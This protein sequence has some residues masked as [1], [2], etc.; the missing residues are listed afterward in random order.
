MSGLDTSA[1]KVSE[2]EDRYFVDSNVLINFL[3]N[4]Y[5]HDIPYFDGW[6]VVFRYLIAQGVIAIPSGIMAELKKKKGQKKKVYE[7][8]QLREIKELKPSNKVHEEKIAEYARKGTSQRILQ[9]ANFDAVAS[10]VK[11]SK[12]GTSEMLNDHLGID[13]GDLSLLATAFDPHFQCRGVRYLV[14]SEFSIA[15]QMVINDISPDKRLVATLEY[16]QQN[17]S[18]AA[19][20]SSLNKQPPDNIF[21]VKIPDAIQDIGR[22]LSKQHASVKFLRMPEFAKAVA[23]FLP[24]S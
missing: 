1:A 4:F 22:F 11:F 7:L 20:S 5:P 21:K 3:D 18:E 16:F 8:L 23:D 10:R 9:L 17:I 15:E 14:S 13:P 19:L 12:A 6:M 2:C 24:S